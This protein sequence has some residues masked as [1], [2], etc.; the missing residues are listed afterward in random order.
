MG[1]MASHITSL[2]IFYSTVCSSTT[3]ESIKAPRH[4]EV[5]DDRRIPH[6]KGQWRGKCFNLMTASCFILLHLVM[7]CRLLILPYAIAM[8]TQHF[9]G[10]KFAIGWFYTTLSWWRHQMDT[11][12]ALLT[13]RS[14]CL[15]NAWKCKLWVFKLAWDLYLQLWYLELS[16]FKINKIIGNTSHSRCTLKSSILTREGTGG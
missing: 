15:S 7:V 14:S 8:K 10:L 3:K 6:T 16:P 4:W 11:F 9:T 5:T 2:T 1:V 13:W 12:S